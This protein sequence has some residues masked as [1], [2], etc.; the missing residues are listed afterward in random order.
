MAPSLLRLAAV[1][2]TTAF[3]SQ[4]AEDH[5]SLAQLAVD[6]QG[7]GVLLRQSSAT[8]AMMRRQDPEEMSEEKVDKDKVLVGDDANAEGT[9]CVSAA[10]LPDS[11]KLFAARV[12]RGKDEL[13]HEDACKSKK[14]DGT[15][16]CEWFGREEF[17]RHLQ[18]KKA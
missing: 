12:C 2:F 15:A 7:A 18:A 1:C 5:R 10:G 16:L 13:A 9:S 8:N 4:I 17:P 14:R 3:A 11:L 6:S